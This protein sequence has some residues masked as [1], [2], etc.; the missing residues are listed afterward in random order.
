M[1]FVPW[2]ARAN[3]SV[4]HRIWLALILTASPV[5]PSF[6]AA[7][8]AAAPTDLARWYVV[9][10]PPGTLNAAWRRAEADA[11]H[12]WVVSL[13][14][15]RPMV[16]RRPDWREEE[17]APL[18]VPLPAGPLRDGFSGSRKFLKVEDGW[19]IGFDKG[20]WGGSLWWFSPDGVRKLQLGEGRVPALIATTKGPVALEEVPRE[21]RVVRLRKGAEG[22]W[23]RDVLLNLEPWPYAIAEDADGSLL[24]A[25]EDH[26]QRIDPN[27]RRAEILSASTFWRGLYPN[28]MI[29]TPQ[30]VIYLGMRHGVARF[31]KAGSGCQIRWLLPDKQ[32][33][34]RDA[35]PERPDDAGFH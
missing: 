25:T 35:E 29:V 16:H 23:E 17:S 5:A 15:G 9:A 10:A 8:E 27:A 11:S 13:D 4:A 21:G 19:I 2:P 30:G 18:P 12:E 20:E 28:S 31:D 32:T 33:A 24:V 14:D 3:W 22:R 7:Q 1:R 6:V 26:L 34:D